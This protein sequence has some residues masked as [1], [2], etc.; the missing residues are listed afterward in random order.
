MSKRHTIVAHGA[1]LKQ[2]LRVEAARSRTTGRQIMTFESLAC[3]LAGEFVHPI[4]DE[5]LRDAVQR[6][7]PIT[8]LGELDPI[9]DLPGFVAAA[10]GTLRKAWRSGL[11]LQDEAVKN[12]RIASVARLEAAVLERLSPAAKRPIDVVE[13]AMARVGLAETLFGSLR[14]V[15]ITELSP[16]WRPLLHGLAA[17]LPVIWDAGPRSVPPW[18][19]TAIVKVERS[20]AAKPEVVCVSA[21]ARLCCGSGRRASRSAV[22]RRSGIMILPAQTQR[23]GSRQSVRRLRCG[24]HQLRTADESM[25]VGGAIPGW[26]GLRKVGLLSMSCDGN[27][28]RLASA[29]MDTETPWPVPQSEQRRC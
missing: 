25:P 14:I 2:E 12:A 17:R 20:E 29:G 27:A 3:R 22:D 6:S 28:G 18:L 11:V 21:P 15:G 4:D 9:K 8:E 1:L 26:S 13:E 10:A 5:V 24:I 16:C 23:A 19:D 7:L